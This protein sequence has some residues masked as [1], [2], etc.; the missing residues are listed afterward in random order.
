MYKWASDELYDNHWLIKFLQ[1]K[2]NVLGV[3]SLRVV[4]NQEESVGQDD[5]DED[6]ELCYFDR[7]RDQIYS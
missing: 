7:K 5:M 6:P 1:R 3:K 4:N 2:L